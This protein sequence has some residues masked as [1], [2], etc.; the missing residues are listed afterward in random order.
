VKSPWIIIIALALLTLGRGDAAAATFSKQQIRCALGLHTAGGR[1]AR[2]EVDRFLAC[3]DAIADGKLPPGQ[4]AATCLAADPRGRIA[5]ARARTDVI[6]ATRCPEPP[7]FGLRNALAV[8]AAFAAMLRIDDSFGPDLEGVVTKAADKVGARC[9]RAV[10]RGVATLARAQLR[11]VGA[12]LVRVLRDKSGVELASLQACFAAGPTGRI[13]HAK[14]QQEGR[15]AKACG[16]VDLGTLFTRGCSGATIGEVLTCAGGEARCGACVALDAA[17][18][19]GASCRAV[20]STVKGTICGGAAFPDSVA[21]SWDE[22][23]LGAIRIDLPRPPVHARNL[24]HLSVAMWDAW[25]AYDDTALQYQHHER[26][27]SQDLARDRATT[28]SFAAYR[29]LRKRYDLSVNAATSRQHFEAR[30]AALGLDVDYTSTTD[31]TPAALGNRIAATVIAANLADGANEAINY[32]DP[33]YAPVNDPMIVKE[34]GTT[35][36]NPNRWQPLALDV[37]IGQNGIP[38]P[39][40]VQIYV[41][42]QWGGVTPFAITRPS[43]SDAY[44]DPGPP[45]Q[46]GGATDALF[47]ERIL[48]V[49]DYARQLTIDDGVMVDIS[50]ASL[51]G[52]SLGT[53][54]GHGY[55]INP[56]T[57]APYVPHLVKRGDYARV[58]AEFWADGPTSETPPGHWNSVANSAVDDPAFV[59]RIGGVG[60]DLDALEWDVKMYLALNGALHDA[61]VQCWGVKRRYDSAR[62]I[63]MIRY[64][65]GLGQSSDPQGPSYHPLG[66]PLEPGLVE[67]ITAESSEPGERHAALAAHVGEIAVYSWPGQPPDPKTQNS[68]V[69]WLRAV[70]WVPYQRNT[71]VTPPFAGY[72]SGHSTYS[73]SAAELLTRLTGSPYFPGGLGEFA[74]SQNDFLQ[75]E[76]GP[77]EA[78]T[79]QWATYYDAAD[80]AGISRLLGGIH[81]ASDDFNGRIAGAQVGAVAFDKALQLFTGGP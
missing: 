53:N 68:G 34:P 58:L 39:G 17:G 57:N 49:L 23:A 26:R 9:Q 30:M 13:A 80:Q 31:D 33:T 28:I 14:R 77:S 50:P 42:S 66:L 43:P 12:C 69:R 36:V 76:I 2:A 78:I 70:E 56:A 60:R 74:V 22:E 73:R 35:M 24:F 27:A 7:P 16:G 62:P 41:G 37:Q 5:A 65:G 72:T 29:V 3:V 11:V 18:A 64:L 40:K 52:S 45:P 46:L 47:K 48:G 51:G 61:A 1:V 55:A 67:V 44:F 59:R 79:L 71:F 4:T 20:G 81:T 38:I 8:N 15:T 54:D 19:L 75:F 21:R 10:A 63:S 25:A 32:S 6:A